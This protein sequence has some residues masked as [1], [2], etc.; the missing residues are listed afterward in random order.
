MHGTTVSSPDKSYQRSSMVNDVV[1]MVTNYLTQTQDYEGLRYF[2]YYD[3]LHSLHY[4]YLKNAIDRTLYIPKLPTPYLINDTITKIWNE[5]S[6]KNPWLFTI[7]D[8][9][10][11]D[12]SPSHIEIARTEIDGIQQKL[13]NMVIDI[14][15]KIVSSLRD[16]VDNIG[17]QIQTAIDAN[18]DRS[19][20]LSLEKEI[21]LIED[22]RSDMDK[23]IGE[24]ENT[25]HEIGEKYLRR[26]ERQQELFAKQH[27]EQRKLKELSDFERKQYE[28]AKNSLESMKQ[29]LKELKDKKR[30]ILTDSEKLKSELIAINATIKTLSNK[31]KQQG[32]SQQEADELLRLIETRSKHHDVVQRLAQEN[33]AIQ[34][35]INPFEKLITPINQLPNPKD[36]ILKIIKTQIS[37]LFPELPLSDSITLEQKIYKTMT[38]NPHNLDIP[39][40]LLSD[41]IKRFVLRL[42]PTISS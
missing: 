3:I 41:I 37:E 10:R 30:E 17:K 29:S 36:I 42:Q 23:S 2:I 13:I 28:E 34:D 14:R 5:M 20:I 18:A 22:A 27:E 6:D 25:F 21:S 1:N 19:V 12:I 39:Q 16:K 35:E 32:L 4:H 9:S 15:N 8:F 26:R 40:Q 33:R 7:Y 31:K 38:N 24:Y 11:Y